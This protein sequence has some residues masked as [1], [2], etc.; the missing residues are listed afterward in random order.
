MIEEILNILKKINNNASYQVRPPIKPSGVSIS[1]HFFNERYVLK[2]DGDGRY[3]G[4][5]L[6]VDIFSTRPALETKNEIRKAIEKTK[7]YIFNYA[8]ERPEDIS[9]QRLYHIIIKFTEKGVK[10]DR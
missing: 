8:D 3:L 9:G 1:F 7:K 4:K 10:N 5:D 2:G 6:Q